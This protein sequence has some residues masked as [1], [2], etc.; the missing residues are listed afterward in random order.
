LVINT[1][2]ALMAQQVRQIGIMK[3]V[4]ARAAQLV[5]MYLSL[6]LVFG[7]LA[8]LI[9]VP[10]GALAAYAMTQYL[11]HLINFDLAGFRLP[12]QALA[13]EVGVGLLVPLL[14]ALYPVLSGARISVYAAITSYGL[15]RGRFGRG[16]FDRL[17]LGR[18]TPSPPPP[19]PSPPGPA[20]RAGYQGEGAREGARS[21]VG[22]P[23]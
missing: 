6:V 16:L 14:A 4:G 20:A 17:L 3:V 22:G 8:L 5:G 10:L 13:L 2:T 23:L 19:Q 9:A 21:T 1:I 12:P 7:L 15:G 11:A 18:R